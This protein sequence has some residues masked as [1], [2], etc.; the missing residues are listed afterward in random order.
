MSRPIPIVVSASLALLV[1]A[2][3]GAPVESAPSP[4]AANVEAGIPIQTL[5]KAVSRKTGK[6]FVID[7]K[8]QGNVEII[9]QDIG[10]VTYS[11][12]LTILQN[13]GFTAVEDGGLLRVISDSTVRQVALPVMVG[14]AAFP[15]AQY[16]GRVISVHHMPAALLVPILRPLLPQHAHLAA[17]VCSNSLLMVDT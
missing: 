6:R 16:I 14:S 10:A 11:E 17:E 2:A 4:T 9:G 13:E 15:D 5:I 7:A 12:L 8:V 3:P 1:G